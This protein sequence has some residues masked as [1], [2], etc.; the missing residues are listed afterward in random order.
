M[1]TR[2]ALDLSWVLVNLVDNA[3]RHTTGPVAV[4]LRTEGADAVLSITDDGPGI[5]KPDQAGLVSVRETVHAH[6]GAVHP[7]DASSGL[8]V[9]MRVSLSW[10]K[11]ACQMIGSAAFAT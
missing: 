6:E 4:E 9:V 10:P 7:E 11:L 3:L 1:V 5:L 2:N 8:C